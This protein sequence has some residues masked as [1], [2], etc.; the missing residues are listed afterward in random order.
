MMPR[1]L[2]RHRPVNAR[3]RS[4]GR[5]P[6][7]LHFC[8]SALLSQGFRFRGRASSCARL[9][10]RGRAPVN[11]TVPLSLGK[12]GAFLQVPTS[13]TILLSVG[14]LV[15]VFLVVFLLISLTR[16]SDPDSITIGSDGAILEELRK[17]DAGYMLPLFL[18]A[19]A[20]VDTH[21]VTTAE[22]LSLVDQEV[23]EGQT[24]F[25]TA[26]SMPLRI[27]SDYCRRLAQHAEQFFNA[28]GI[29]PDTWRLCA[30]FRGDDCSS[31]TDALTV[32]G[33]DFRWDYAT[34]GLLVPL[35]GSEEPALVML[36]LDWR[37]R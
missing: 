12:K 36:G 18:R 9:A 26:Q 10:R 14:V 30:A 31:P 11:G 3:C 33:G 16:G 5:N 32:G 22:L 2:P 35:P 13:L 23:Q 20:E 21:N 29:A 7:A 34:A 19:Q 8:C 28:S 24:C 4:L 15:L 6:N 27:G 1:I 25:G 37:E 17:M